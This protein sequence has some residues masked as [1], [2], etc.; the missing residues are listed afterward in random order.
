MR[1]TIAALTG[2]ALLLVGAS[3]TI[4]QATHEVVPEGSIVVERVDPPVPV[5]VPDLVCGEGETA[6]DDLSTCVPLAEEPV[7]VAVTPAPEPEPVQ[8]GTVEV[9]VDIA[10]LPC[11]DGFVMAEDMTCVPLSFYDEP[12]YSEPSPVV[13]SRWDGLL[14]GDV[15]VCPPGFEVSIDVTPAGT[16]WAACM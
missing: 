3:A 4:N 7:P 2:T 10:P 9:G 15:I 12:A 16:T 6:S 8:E 13:G 14:V 1:T 11:E 5:T